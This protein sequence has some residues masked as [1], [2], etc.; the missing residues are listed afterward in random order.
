MAEWVRIL[1]A[2]L[3]STTP[4]LGRMQRDDRRTSLRRN[5]RPILLGMPLWSTPPATGDQFRCR[6]LPVRGMD[7]TRRQTGILRSPVQS[8]FVVCQPPLE[9]RDH[10]FHGENDRLDLRSQPHPKLRGE[11]CASPKVLPKSP[12]LERP[13]STDRE[14]VRSGCERLLSS[15]QSAIPRFSPI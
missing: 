4:A 1:P 5:Q 13:I 9:A 3:R 8:R 11:S 2:Q 10:N 7:R 14:V 15:T 6:L 12:I